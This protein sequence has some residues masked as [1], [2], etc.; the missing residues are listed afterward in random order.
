MEISIKKWFEGHDPR[1]KEKRDFE[2][3][4][5][6]FLSTLAPYIEELRTSNDDHLYRFNQWTEWKTGPDKE[7][8]VNH[9]MITSLVPDPEGLLFKIQK[10]HLHPS[11]SRND[12]RKY[13]EVYSIAIHTDVTGE[14]IK[15]IRFYN[16]S[17][18][19]TRAEKLF[20]NKTP[21]DSYTKVDK[22]TEQTRIL[23][24]AIGLLKIKI[25]A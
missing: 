2:K 22:L 4:Q 9:R 10:F 19:S 3:A 21:L 25:P 17:S 12:R 1:T 8:T 14:S 6:K 16:L 24:R 15:D 23:N 13:A 7:Y 11:L 18:Y 5:A 20:K